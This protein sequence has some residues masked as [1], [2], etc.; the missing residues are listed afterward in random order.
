MRAYT[1]GYACNGAGWTAKTANGQPSSGRC[2][3]GRSTGDLFQHGLHRKPSSSSSSRRAQAPLPSSQRDSLP[4]APV[5]ILC[6]SLLALLSTLPIPP[7]S[8]APITRTLLLPTLRTARPR[9]PLPPVRAYPDTAL[10]CCLCDLC[11]TVFY[12]LFISLS[13]PTALCALVQPFAHSRHPT[14]HLRTDVPGQRPSF[15]FD[16]H[17]S[18]TSTPRPPPHPPHSVAR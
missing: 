12:S 18:T 13:C 1:A 10:H 17:T 3:R 16:L 15:P 11:S 14:P 6:Q 4:T 9:F 5:C 7:L 2:V 8:L